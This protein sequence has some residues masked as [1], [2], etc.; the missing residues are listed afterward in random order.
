MST[1]HYCSPDQRGPLVFMAFS[2]TFLGNTIIAEPWRRKVGGEGV[3]EGQCD[4][5]PK[6]RQ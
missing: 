1:W 4:F 2:E 6:R 5:T 3:C